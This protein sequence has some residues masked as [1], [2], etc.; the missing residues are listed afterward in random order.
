MICRAE[1]S[2]AHFL[3]HIHASCFASCWSEEYFHQILASSN[4]K[5]LK[6]VIDDSV[7]GFCLYA[8]IEPEIEILTLCV[9]E[10][11]RR[12]KIAKSL[13]IH[14]I[15]EENFDTIFLETSIQN[16]AAIELYKSV[17]FQKYSKRKNYYYEN[18]HLYDALLFKYT[19]ILK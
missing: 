3:S 1:Q 5:G 6:S 12:M 9:L 14:I 18:G 7:V 19:C 13:L 8:F 11:F 16:R 10:Q 17:G 2:D 15:E 4:H